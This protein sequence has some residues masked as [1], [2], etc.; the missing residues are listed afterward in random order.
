[1]DKINLSF[2]EMWQR[3]IAC[4][5]NYDGYFYT[6][7]KTTKIY[8]RPSCKSRKPKKEN[9]VFYKTKSEAE[10][11]GF[12]ACKR[13]KPDLQLA[14]QEDLVEQVISFLTNNYRQPLTLENISLH[15]G[16]S[17]FHLE[18]V[19]KKVTSESPRQLL[20]RIRIEKAA[21]LLKHTNASNLEI[22]LKTGFQ[23]TSTFYKAFRNSFQ[24]SPSEFRKQWRKMQV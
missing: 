1:M 10:K 13:C 15:M 20:E 12:R 17:P 8:C 9:V 6:A 22:S 7:V 11:A 16:V 23:S 18:R 4:D 24:S 5:H 14:P 2:E 3:I 19:F 21:H